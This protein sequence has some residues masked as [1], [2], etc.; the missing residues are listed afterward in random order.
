[1][2]KTITAASV[3]IGDIA[4]IPLAFVIWLSAAITAAHAAQTSSSFSGEKTT[5]HGFDRHDFVMDEAGLSIMPI[6]AG[7]DEKDGIKNTTAGQRRCVIVVPKT[8]A[9]GNPWSWRGCYW[10]HQPQ[11]EIELL[12]RGFHI[13]YIESSATLRPDKSWD[14]WYAFLTEQH[15]LSKKPAFVGMS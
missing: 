14:A 1:M 13:A 4:S 7:E 3:R 5:W 11:A 2:K 9:P 10:D 12:R 6:K 15:G 8:A